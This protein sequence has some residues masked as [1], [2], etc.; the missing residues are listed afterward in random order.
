MNEAVTRLSGAAQ[1]IILH[2]ND[3][4]IH[5]IKRIVEIFEA[6]IPKVEEQLMVLKNGHET[7][8]DALK[9]ESHLIN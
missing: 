2:T 3:L 1:D 6:L 7:H 8:W 9:T 4:D 5:E